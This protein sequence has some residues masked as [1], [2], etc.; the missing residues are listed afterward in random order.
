[1]GVVILS[2][3]KS[4]FVYRTENNIFYRV[5]LISF[6]YFQPIFAQDKVV[7]V[8]DP[9]KS[10]EISPNPD[11]I[12]E[13]KHIGEIFIHMAKIT[14]AS[15]GSAPALEILFASDKFVWEEAYSSDVTQDE[16]PNSDIVQDDD[17]GKNHKDKIKK[18]F[19]EFIPGT[20]IIFNIT[21]RLD[22]VTYYRLDGVFPYDVPA[23]DTP[24]EKQFLKR[25]VFFKFTATAAK[26]ISMFK[27][28][29]DNDLWAFDTYSKLIWQYSMPTDYDKV[30]GNNYIPRKWQPFENSPNTKDHHLK[31]YEYDPIGFVSEK[32]EHPFYNAK[33]N[34]CIYD[35]W[36]NACNAGKKMKT[37]KE[38]RLMPAINPN[39]N[40]D[41]T[42]RQKDIPVKSP[43]GK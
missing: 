41:W 8:V 29:L 36:L 39:A 4:M 17:W 21:N 33:T 37:V 13:S 1:M 14:Q 6:F 42:I 2:L 40:P 15:K 38:K 9:C 12:F 43:Y 3:I 31:F 23:Y 22:D 34:I 35:W 19:E 10:I 25:F 16:Q 32:S 28:Y 27:Q 7:D 24:S 5:L 11:S 18:Y 20:H 30:I 26:Q